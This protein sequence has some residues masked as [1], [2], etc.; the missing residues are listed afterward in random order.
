VA[1][2]ERA[3]LQAR[4]VKVSIEV[5]SVDVGGTTATAT[6]HQTVDATAADG[7]PVR[8]SGTVVFQLVRQ[9]AGWMITEIK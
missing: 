4:E 2:A 8:T 9:P 1:D 6:C 7:K 3:L 5:S